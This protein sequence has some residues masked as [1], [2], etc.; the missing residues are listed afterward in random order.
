MSGY[1][2]GTSAFDVLRLRRMTAI[3]GSQ[4]YT[5]AMLIESIQRYPVEDAD[6]YAPDDDQWEPTYDIARAACEIWA[7]KAACH[8]RQL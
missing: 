1:T 3:T 7:E 8:G 6:G 4:T 2:G 5:D